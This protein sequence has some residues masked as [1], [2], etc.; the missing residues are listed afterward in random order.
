M[1]N[2]SLIVVVILALVAVGTGVYVGGRALI[3][4]LK[5]K[6]VRGQE[7][8]REAGRCGG[9]VASTLRSSSQENVIA[10]AETVGGHGGCERVERE[11]APVVKKVRFSEEVFEIGDD[12]RYGYG[13]ARVLE[14]RYKR[15]S[16]LG[17]RWVERTLADEDRAGVV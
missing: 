3:R 7:A 13:E 12:Y 9:N 2:Y 8:E 5:K 10:D 6:N 15:E 14:R 16:E 4:S 1:N 17:T 11:E